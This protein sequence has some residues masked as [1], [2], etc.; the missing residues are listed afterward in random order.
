MLFT[1]F[2]VSGPVIL[3]AS[4]HLCDYSFGSCTL[5][6]DLKPALD[7]TTLDARLLREFGAAANRTL[8]NVL[9][10][11]LPKSLVPVLLRLAGVSPDLK[12]NAVTR[13]QRRA[14]LSVMKKFPVRI[15]G[16]R[17]VEEAVIT[18]GGVSFGE[19]DSHSMASRLV[20]GLYFA[21]ELIDADAY[22]GGF[23]LQIA[24]ST[25]HLAGRKA[26]AYAAEH[27]DDITEE[28]TPDRG[29]VNDMEKFAV[30]IDGP[31]GAG[32][33]T[34]AKALA[35]R[36][37]CI[38]VDTGALYRAVGLFVRRADAAPDDPEAVGA[39]LP[40]LTVDLAYNPPEDARPGQRVLLCGEDVSDLIRTPEISIY[41]SQ[42]SKIPAVRS[43]LLDIQRG[44]AAKHSVVMDGRDIGTVILPDAE[45]KIFL[46][47]SPEVRAERRYKELIEKGNETTYE[48]VLRDLIWRDKNDSEREIA[49]LRAAEDA[50]LLDTSALSLEQSVAA[51]EQLVSKRLAERD[52]L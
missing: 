46:T 35:A 12:V 6:I 20:E 33:S 42:V 15:V 48:E 26:A 7:E 21:G 50:V 2:G 14:I 24:W 51:A 47:A 52:A 40:K 28:R 16:L 18:S 9:Q 43:A 30:A 36:L 19:I 1:H 31:N 4:A 5:T 10:A 34:I 32:K 8:A 38:Y 3:S 22:T 49:P 45:V 29:L 41:A 25:G 37:G 13:E 17:P 23:N 11:L 27:T 39:L 44:L